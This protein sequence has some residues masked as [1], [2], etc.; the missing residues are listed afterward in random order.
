MND[1]K[2]MP[3]MAAGGSVKKYSDG[4]STDKPAK[5]RY[6]VWNEAKMEPLSKEYKTSKGAQKT[7]ES[8]GGSIKDMSTWQPKYDYSK[9]GAGQDTGNYKRPAS[10]GGSMGGGDMS[11]MKGLDKPYK[12]GGKV[13]K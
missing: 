2:K 6:Q 1:F 5:G 11:G 13:K 4:G 8:T 12:R 10:G 7:A 9:T 3:R